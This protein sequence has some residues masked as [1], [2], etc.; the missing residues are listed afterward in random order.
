M[1]YTVYFVY[2]MYFVQIKNKMM[3]C[4]VPKKLTVIYIYIMAYF[5]KKIYCR[6]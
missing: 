6:L 5:G 4:S 1:L 3:F 2:D